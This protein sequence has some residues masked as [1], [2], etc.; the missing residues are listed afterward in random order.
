VLTPHSPVQRQAR[1]SAVEFGDETR[2]RRVVDER[3]PEK[4][5]VVEKI[6]HVP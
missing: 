5:P 6:L 2:V 1:E 3:V 4:T